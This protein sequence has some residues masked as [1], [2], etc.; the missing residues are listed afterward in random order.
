MNSARPLNPSILGDF[1]ACMS[2]LQTL[3]EPFPPILGDGRGLHFVCERDLI[4]TYALA[5]CIPQFSIH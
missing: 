2:A 5:P 3:K 4:K 1:Q